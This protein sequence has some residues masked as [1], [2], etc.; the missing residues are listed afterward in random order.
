MTDDKDTTEEAPKRSPFKKKAPAKKSAPKTLRYVVAEGRSIST[1]GQI[2]NE[3]DEIT[4]EQVADI[5]ALLKGGF[6]VKA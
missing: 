4:A 1:G 6:V 3:G 5:E 2:I